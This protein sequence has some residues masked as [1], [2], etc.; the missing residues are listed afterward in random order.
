MKRKAKIVA[1]G[2][3]RKKKVADN[4]EIISETESVISDAV[5][6]SGFSVSSKASV[7]LSVRS[8]SSASSAST[9]MPFLT[10]TRQPK[11]KPAVTSKS[12]RGDSPK[13]AER[14]VNFKNEEEKTERKK[15]Y[16]PVTRSK[17]LAPTDPLETYVERI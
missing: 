11:V 13:A 15:S 8:V 9:T 3:P 10:F 4:G 2:R 12:E 1:A 6:D 14:L 16:S 7:P 17:P 5:S